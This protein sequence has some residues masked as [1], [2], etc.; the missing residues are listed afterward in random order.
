MHNTINLNGMIRGDGCFTEGIIVAI[1]FNK[2]DTIPL[3][4][5]SNQALGAGTDYDLQRP[6]GQLS[7]KGP[8]SQL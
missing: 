7:P 2:A 4:L 5:P 8:P 6:W 3:H 1:F